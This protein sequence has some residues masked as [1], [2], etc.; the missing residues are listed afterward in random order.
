[1]KKNEV[2]RYKKLDGVINKNKHIDGAIMP[3][4]QGA[5]EIFG[6]LS[7]KVMNY[8]SNKINVSIEQLY[9]TATF[10]SQFRFKPIGKYKISLC[11]GTVC[12]VKGSGAILEE[13]TRILGINNGE[14]TSDG[15]FSIDT[16]RC[17]GCCGMAPVVMINDDVYGNVTKDKVKSI[18]E[19]YK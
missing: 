11:L 13:I 10:Y 7:F 5:Q 1:M 3:I 2:T 4:L 17:L 16:T 9:S 19:K 18:L 8:I 14:C 12:Y 6:Y 15:K